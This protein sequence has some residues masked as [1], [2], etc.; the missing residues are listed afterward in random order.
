R[1]QG[2]GTAVVASQQDIYSAAWN[3]AGLAGL[4]AERGVEIGAMHAEWFGGV[5][6]YDFLGFTLPLN[7][8]NQRIGLSL[9]RFGV[10]QI[11]NTLSLYESD[12]TINFYNVVEFSAAD[13]AFLGT[14]ARSYDKG[15][16][17]L[18]IGANVKVIHRRI[19]PFATSWGFGLDIGAQLERGNWTFA[20]LAKDITTTFNAWTFSL[21]QEEQDILQITGNNL[22]IDGIETTHPQVLLGLL[23]KFRFNEQIGLQTELNFIVTTDG[24]RNTLISGDPFSIDPAFGLEADYGQ[25]VFVRA[26]VS[27]FQ[28]I[29]DFDGTEVLNSRP[30]LGLGLKIGQ[31][32]VD[33]AY[34]DLGDDRATFSHIISARLGLQPKER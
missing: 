7:N 27:Q 10:D 24:Q 22:P 14:Y 23:R 4:P 34:T 21:T 6:N 11:P 29:L 18:R 1:A 16:G 31:L 33:Y 32:Y 15:K 3:P 12:G 28:Q 19:G 30:S 25:F 2:M 20:L 17:P 8:K 9:I 26:G 13:Y 5:G